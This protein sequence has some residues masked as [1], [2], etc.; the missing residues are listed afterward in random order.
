MSTELFSVERLV[1]VI[2]NVPRATA[3]VRQAELLVPQRLWIAADSSGRPELFIRGAR[4]SFGTMDF[5][6][7]LSWD[8]YQIADSGE[9]LPA[10][11]VRA[12]SGPPG[13]R[14]MA[15]I[16][17]EAVRLLGESPGLS[18][19]ALVEQLR[20]F[21]RL[22]VGQ[23]LLTSEEQTGL[24]GELQLLAELL[25][26]CSDEHARA[27]ALETWVGPQGGLRDFF[28]NG[29]AIEVKASADLRHRVGFEQILPRPEEA[30]YLAS[31]RVRRDASASL[32]LP[33]LVDRTAERLDDHLVPDFEARLASYG[34]VGYRTDGSGA[35]RSASGFFVDAAELRQIDNASPILRRESFSP[36][37]PSPA[38]SAISYALDVSGIPLLHPGA[39]NAALLALSAPRG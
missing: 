20:P 3:E 23:P 5:N 16:A 30:L 39:K 21:L 2:R 9:P 34:S 26:L 24:V 8:S 4:T 11:V 27:R 12:A 38:V 28:A 35:Y 7:L 6:P 19:L 37:H 13:H 1:E 10:C 29:I 22:G 17:Y 32:T 31:V 33:D 25:Q 15:H 36:G 18:N 14:L